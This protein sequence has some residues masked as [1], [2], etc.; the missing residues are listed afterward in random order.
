M[1][2]ALLQPRVATIVGVVL[3]IGI[4]GYAPVGPELVFVLPS[5]VDQI[6]PQAL[7]GRRESDHCSS[8]ECRPVRP[9]S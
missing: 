9:A 1:E 2:E 6:G 8:L 7:F 3:R 4:L 5:K